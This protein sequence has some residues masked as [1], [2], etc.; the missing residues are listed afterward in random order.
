MLLCHVATKNVRHADAELIR[1]ES[2]DLISYPLERVKC[3]VE[4]TLTM[5]DGCIVGGLSYARALF[6]APTMERQLG[7]LVTML[8]ALV[9][10][11]EQTVAGVD[12]L[13]ADEREQLLRTWNRTERDYPSERCIHQRTML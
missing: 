1:I 13:A 12:L 2:I 5:V 3:D 4:L 7:Y 9:A 11:A 6:D 10:D 8:R